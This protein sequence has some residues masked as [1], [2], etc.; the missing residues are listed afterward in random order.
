MIDLG[1]SGKRAVVAGAGFIASH[2]GHGRASALTLARAGATV[3]CID[4]DKTRANSI[5]A[6]ITAAGGQAHAVVADM[7]E[8]DQ[9]EQ[10]VDR[11]VQT[12]GG[13]DVCVDII[14]KTT[15][16]RVEDIGDAAWQWTMKNNL[17]HVLYL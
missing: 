6:E 5:V 2:A 9:V 3:V 10:A 8:R 7:T 1:L 17:T 15:F 14:G 16:D 12:M 11:A 4:I 13:V